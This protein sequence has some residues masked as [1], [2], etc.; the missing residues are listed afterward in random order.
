MA[1]QK[2]RVAHWGARA[3]ELLPVLLVGVG[4]L[5]MAVRMGMKRPD[6]SLWYDI[7]VAAMFLSTMVAA[8]LVFWIGWRWNL[9]GGLLYGV[10]A[11]G[12]LALAWQTMNP[13][14]LL[15]AVAFLVGGS[16]FVASYF[17]ERGRT[18]QDE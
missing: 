14:G 13:K 3:L 7:Q 2:K 16:M 4:A 10:T 6:V 17:L 11:V 12:F 15:L 9:L 5:W 18:V 1:S 8:I